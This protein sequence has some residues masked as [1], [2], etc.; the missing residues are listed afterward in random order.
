MILLG[1]IGIAWRAIDDVL[2]VVER[3]CM[4]FWRCGGSSTN[5]PAI[6]ALLVLISRG[7]LRA[8]DGFWLAWAN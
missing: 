4:I 8:D 6:S 5:G 7:M 3:T 1:G 2:L